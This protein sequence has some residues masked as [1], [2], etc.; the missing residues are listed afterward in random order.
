MIC[1]HFEGIRTNQKT[2]VKVED[3]TRNKKLETKE[4]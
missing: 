4:L 3:I 1:E 2:E